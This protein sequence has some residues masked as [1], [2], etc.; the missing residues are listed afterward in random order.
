MVAPRLWFISLAIAAGFV[1]ASHG[2]VNDGCASAPPNPFHPEAAYDERIPTP[3]DILGFRIGERSAHP[4]EAVLYLKAL[5]EVSPRVRFEQYGESYGNRPL[6]YVAVTSREN[7]SRLGRIRENLARLADPR[8]LPSDEAERLIE[9]TPAVVWMQHT[10]HGKELSGTDSALQLAY[11][12]AAGESED[13]LDLLD[14]LIVCI[15]PL[16]NP[17]GRALG[18]SMIEQWSG[19]VENPDLYDRTISEGWMDART[20][21]Y[22]FDMNRDQ[23]LMTQKESRARIPTIVSWKPQVLIDA[24]EMGARSTYLFSPE[25]RPNT[26]HAS[27]ALAEWSEVFMKDQ[28][29]AFDERGFPYYTGEWHYDRWYPGYTTSWCYLIGAV[30]ILYEQATVAGLSVRK[31]DGEV[32]DYPRTVYQQYISSIA[33]LTTAAGH[34][35][36]LLRDYYQ[37]RVDWLESHSLSPYYYLLPPGENPTR[38]NRLIETLR[39]QE[40]EIHVA[41]RAFAVPEAKNYWG[42]TRGDEAFPSGTVV[43]TS[44]QPMGRLLKSVLDFDPRLD[45]ESIVD[46]RKEI[47]QRYSSLQYDV[48]GWSMPITFHLD[49]YAHRGELDVPLSLHESSFAPEGAVVNSG[50]VFGYLLNWNDDAAPIALARFFQRDCVARAAR[51]PFTLE[52][53][54]YPLGSVFIQ[55]RGSPE[56]L[57]EIAR[58][59]ADE[60]GV[61]LYGVNTAKSEKGRDLGGGY[62]TL[63]QEPRIA[64]F[65][66]GPLRGNQSG[67]TWQVFDEHLG[68]RATMLNAAPNSLNIGGYDLSRYNVIILPSA[69][70]GLLGRVL[71]DGGINALKTWIEN[72]GTLIAFDGAMEA[73]A[74]T[75][76]ALSQAKRVRDALDELDSYQRALTLEK[77]LGPY[78]IDEE[79]LWG[80]RLPDPVFPA[81]IADATPAKRSEEEDAYLRR[82]HPRGP[83]V[84]VN[85][86]DEHWLSAGVGDRV[87]AVLYTSTAYLANRP[88]AVGRLSDYASIRLS[89]LFWPEGRIRWA[90][91]VYL[92]REG[93]GRGQVILFAGD[94][95]FRVSYHGTTRLLINAALLG[96]GMGASA[97]IPW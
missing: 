15:D 37:D 74:S 92:T 94:P 76:L 67:Q 63:L 27:Q 17:D 35:E 88:V 73:A 69:S 26:P 78:E 59:I 3:Q 36:L 58:A 13:V 39:L 6:V 91:T 90:D 48:Q 34:R 16:A 12:L 56:E 2:F 1:I 70:P 22:Q 72:G 89:G 42:E 18:L 11:H 50:A 38:L 83:I 68:M 28:A 64:I 87:P 25:T 45:D 5:A 10:I 77:N 85:L 51:E 30:G 4:H 53:R 55:R 21:R 75:T 61:T 65:S 52:G 80:D 71:G 44:N 33:N 93:R 41:E 95:A 57:D 43:L 97:S 86:N 84:R 9:D 32:I 46:E 29:R 60:T 24:H 54:S 47:E 8:D 14:N 49:C 66:G 23:F 7:H 20:S 40:V 81:N 79:L 96:P 19:Q 62:F 31:E 82:Y